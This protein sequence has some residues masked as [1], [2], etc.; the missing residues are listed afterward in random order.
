MVE[1]AVPGAE[2]GWV[3]VKDAAKRKAPEGV[4]FPAALREAAAAA[5]SETGA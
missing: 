3:L 1:G 2:G 4:P 5:P